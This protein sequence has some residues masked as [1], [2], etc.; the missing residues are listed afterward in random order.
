MQLWNAA[1]ADLTGSRRRLSWNGRW[2]SRALSLARAQCS[3]ERNLVSNV[4]AYVDFYTKLEKLPYGVMNF[5]F[6]YSNGATPLK[7]AYY[8]IGTLHGSSGSDGGSYYSN[9]M[10]GVLD[11]HATLTGCGYYNCANGDRSTYYRGRFWSIICAFNHK[12]D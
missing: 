11:L 2:A 5:H 10:D 7:D 4:N 12:W 8:Y 9:G 3:N 6:G 1:R